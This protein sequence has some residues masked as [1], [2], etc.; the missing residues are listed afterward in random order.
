MVVI[1]FK[2]FIWILENNSNFDNHNEFH[3]FV[4]LPKFANF[5]SILFEDLKIFL[6]LNILNTI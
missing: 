5:F 4:E 2:L 1:T 6:E 3:L